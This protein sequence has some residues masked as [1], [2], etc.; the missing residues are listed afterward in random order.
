MT[1]RGRFHRMHPVH[2]LEEFDEWETRILIKKQIRARV[3][4]LLTLSYS[5]TESNFRVSFKHGTQ[6]KERENS[7]WN[8]SSSS[9]VLR[10]AFCREALTENAFEWKP[11][12]LCHEF[13]LILTI[14]SLSDK[15][16]LRTTNLDT[17]WDRM[18]NLFTK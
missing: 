6:G 15:C 1:R 7:Y 5:A 9:E 3:N 18:A 10:T 14:L 8:S 12:K 13:K 16:W 17:I 11:Y 4:W 2:S